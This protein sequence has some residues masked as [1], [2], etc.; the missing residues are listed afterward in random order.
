MSGFGIF[1][2]ALDMIIPTG[3]L[4]STDS[5]MKITSGM[6]QPPNPSGGY[7][8][9]GQQECK[10]FRKARGCA[11]DSGHCGVTV[12]SSMKAS[13][14]GPYKTLL[15]QRVMAAVISL[16]HIIHK[17]GAFLCHAAVGTDPL[18][19]DAKHEDV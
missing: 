6:V 10:Y 19:E 4:N 15:K 16:T 8:R 1:N 5:V 17:T 12:Q 14:H 7:L 9:S 3:M 2:D 18:W 13:H 11:P